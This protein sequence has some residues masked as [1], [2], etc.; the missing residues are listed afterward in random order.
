MQHLKQEFRVPARFERKTGV[1]SQR[2][3]YEE[4]LSSEQLS[5]SPRKMLAIQA[6]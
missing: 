5:R 3:S 2:P 1:L 6:H 4:R